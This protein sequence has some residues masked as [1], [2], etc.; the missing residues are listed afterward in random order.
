MNEMLDVSRIEHDMLTL[1]CDDFDLA[2][3]LREVVS[4]MEILS[5]GFRFSL[6]MPDDA[7]EVHGD[8][9]R[10]EQ[11]VT[12]LLENAVKYSRISATD[13]SGGETSEIEVS[14]KV[15]PPAGEETGVG[16]RRG[17]VITAVRDHGVGIP[18]EQQSQVFNRFFR[19][20]NVTTAYYPYPGMGLGL[21]VAHSIIERHGGRMWVESAEKRGSTFSFS[22]P[23]AKGKAEEPQ[24]S[25]GR[26]KSSE[27]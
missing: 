25:A 19:A 26:K 3:L 27:F 17:E 16:S 11:V 14:I 23:Q 13:D 8:R 5:S 1:T 21:F 6:D 22:L 2:E 24:L 10:I 18:A 9:Q 7:V 12:N 4:S 15:E 20:S